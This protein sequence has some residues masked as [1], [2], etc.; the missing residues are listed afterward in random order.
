MNHQ[1]KLPEYE[2]LVT[3]IPTD[4]RLWS[5]LMQDTSGN[6]KKSSRKLTRPEAFYDL[7]KR[8]RMTAHI[9]GQPI[10]AGGY[11]ELADSWGWDRTTVRRFLHSLTEVGMVSVEITPQNK[12]V[13][14]LPGV[15]TAP[16]PQNNAGDS[17]Q[18]NQGDSG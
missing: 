16:E 17:L 6:P 4:F 14:R 1:E 18:G 10:A 12:A 5:L 7:L 13:I 8:Q 9:P 3:L 2:G 11:Q 15:T